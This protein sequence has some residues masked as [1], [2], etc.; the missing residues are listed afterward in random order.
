MPTEL[1][2]YQLYILKGSGKGKTQK[3]CI[4]NVAL[5]MWNKIA[6]PLP[7][8]LLSAYAAVVVTRTITCYEKKYEALI[9]RQQ[10]A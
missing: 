9:H 8:D 7:P 10:V 6:Q 4:Q 1:N 2:T 3:Y 5:Q